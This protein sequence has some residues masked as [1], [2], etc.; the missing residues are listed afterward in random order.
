M[1]AFFVKTG[2]YTAVY[3]AGAL[4]YSLLEIMWRGFTHWTM[5]LTGGAC[6][7]CIYF[8]DGILEG[9]RMWKKC[10]AGCAVITLLEFAVGCVVNL[11]LG[12]NVWD[13]SSRPANI[14]GQICPSFC[15]IWFA[16]SVPAFKICDFMRN[17]L[18]SGIKNGEPDH[19]A[20]K[21]RI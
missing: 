2:E 19:A 21:S 17:R 10:F 18:F 15:A 6:L 20:R 13:Y 11:R 3:G 4:I 5:T 12:W 9:E 7:A 8:L 16:L 14:M 1:R